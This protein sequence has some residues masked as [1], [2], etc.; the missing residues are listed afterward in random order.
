MIRFSLLIQAQ[1]ALWPA[2][3]ASLR[4]LLLGAGAK[5][6]IATSRRLAE[7][8]STPTTPLEALKAAAL[9]ARDNDGLG[10]L[11]WCT[12]SGG[13]HLS[14]NLCW[15]AA[16]RHNQTA[17]DAAAALAWPSI[18]LTLF[19]LAACRAARQ[20]ASALTGQL[21]GPLG[22]LLHS[23]GSHATSGGTRRRLSEGDPLAQRMQERA[24]DLAERFRQLGAARSALH[25][26]LQEALGLGSNAAPARRLRQADEADAGEGPRDGA[27]GDE[28]WWAG[29][30][31]YGS[32]VYPGHSEESLAGVL[33]VEV[34]RASTHF[35]SAPPPWLH[36]LPAGRCESTV[37]PG[38]GACFPG[39]PTVPPPA[40]TLLPAQDVSLAPLASGMLTAMLALAR[41]ALDVAISLSAPSPADW[42]A[43][44]GASLPQLLEPLP[45]D[46]PSAIDD[47]E[48][49]G[50][51]GRPDEEPAAL[52]NV[53]A[54]PAGSV[55]AA[56][57]QP[58]LP[59]GEPP[60][61]RRRLRQSP[62][63][64]DP[65]YYDESYDDSD[66]DYRW[67]PG[68][69]LHVAVVKQS[70]RAAPAGWPG[71][72]AGRPRFPSLPRLFPAMLHG[73]WCCREPTCTA[74]SSAVLLPATDAS[75]SARIVPTAGEPA[76]AWKAPCHS[77]AASAPLS[78]PLSQH[79]PFPLA[80]LNTHAHPRAPP[81]QRQRVQRGGLLC[82]PG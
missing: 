52:A 15:T 77:R 39:M 53:G 63:Y 76:A 12:G 56:R 32:V 37:P 80:P 54:V 51:L 43:A 10:Q 23:A 41:D 47:P 33:I 17:Q 60:A 61:R 55:A 38:P 21:A 22:A 11:R 20:A 2:L 81:M 58:P 73:P 69:C 34:R 13:V 50:P 68:V 18:R 27:V 16:P 26:R 44:Y 71:R 42:R 29:D 30:E 6:P 31:A 72:P 79:L 36:G 75:C 74:S 70:A 35:G 66:G 59:A 65:S 19:V 24:A 82:R 78:L 1:D 62:A 4:P 40:C 46:Y 67:E 45:M 3:G 7:D 9:Q 25:S 57:Q 48:G 28:W 5:T 14:R 49:P 8:G 64:D